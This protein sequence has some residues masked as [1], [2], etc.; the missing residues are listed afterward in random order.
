M[1]LFSATMLKGCV[2]TGDPLLNVDVL[3]SSHQCGSTGDGPSVVLIRQQSEL[4][5]LYDRMGSYS[6]L[7]IEVPKLD[8]EIESVVSIE[9][10]LRTTGGYGIYLKNPAVLV[11]EGSLT[12]WVDWREPSPSMLQTQALTSPCLLLKVPAGGYGY[13]IVRD[14][15]GTVRGRSRSVMVGE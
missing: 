12:V 3:L 5:R 9:M 8:F 2:S 4:E 11:E 6:I 7:P 13:V 10:G 15:E 14:S 1:L